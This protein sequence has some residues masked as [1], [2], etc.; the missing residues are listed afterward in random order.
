MTYR[1][2]FVAAAVAL[3]ILGGCATGTGVQLPP[4][5]GI[6]DYQLGQP[7]APAPGVTIVVRDHSEPPAGAGYDICYVN[8]FQT[9]PEELSE[10]PADLV[11]MTAQG[12]PITDPNW[13]GEALLDTATTVQRT[14][15]ANQLGIQIKQCAQAGF[16]AVEFDNLDS[17][18]RSE[19]RLTLDNNIALAKLLVAEAHAHNLAVAQKNTAEWSQRLR[20]EAGFD[21]AIAEECAKF[22]ECAAY[23]DVYGDAV[24]DIEYSADLELSF[25]QRCA[26]ADSPR[27]MILRDR[28]LVTPGSR[29]YRFET[30]PPR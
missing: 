16:D 11:L 17:F 7:Y 30:C 13:P 28:D 12:A 8:A 19:G 5:G 1:R 18:S 14:A 29:G 24:I 23:G 10:W 6:P 21:F 15:I 4:A 20:A 9:Q 2:S 3:T 27:S 25:A 22:G 26:H